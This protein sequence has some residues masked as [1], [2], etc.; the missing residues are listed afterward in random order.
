MFINNNIVIIWH[1]NGKRYLGGWQYHYLDQ[2][3]KNGLALEYIPDQYIYYGQ[4]RNNKKHGL[5][6]MKEGPNQLKIGYW[7]H[8]VYQGTT[9]NNHHQHQQQQ[10]QQQYD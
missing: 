3:T 10:Q 9:N 8:G 6:A 4:F 2:G 7:H 1:F 5:G